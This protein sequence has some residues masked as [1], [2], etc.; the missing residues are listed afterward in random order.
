MHNADTLAYDLDHFCQDA[1]AAL[2]SAQTLSVQLEAI[3]QQLHLL[4]LNKEFVA[5]TF[6]EETPAGKDVL[7]HDPEFDFYVQAHMQGR[8]AP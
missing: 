6:N 2:A 5:A 3:A 4:L 1:R 7:Y 8:S